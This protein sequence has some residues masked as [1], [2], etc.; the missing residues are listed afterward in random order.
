MDGIEKVDS[1]VID[2]FEELERSNNINLGDNIVPPL[3]IEEIANKAWGLEQEEIQQM[4]I[5]NVNNYLFDIVELQERNN[6]RFAQVRQ[7]YDE[8]KQLQS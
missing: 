6:L 3:T 4:E 2:Y 7:D 8:I 1:S 5:K